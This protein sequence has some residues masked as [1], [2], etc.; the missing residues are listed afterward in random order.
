M[1][2]YIIMLLP[3]AALFTAPYLRYILSFRKGVRF[4]Y[5]IHMVFAILVCLA[6][7]ALNYY[8]FPPRNFLIW[9]FGSLGLI[10]LVVIIVRKYENKEKKLIFMTAAFSLVFNFGNHYWSCIYII[11]WCL[12][13]FWLFQII[14]QQARLNPHSLWF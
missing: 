13:P 8:F 14:K 10:G 4:F 9:L 6:I 11:F 3:L 12:L 5:P 7:V 1:P 2:H